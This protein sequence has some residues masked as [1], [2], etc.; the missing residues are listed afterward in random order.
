MASRINPAAQA[1]HNEFT[2]NKRL[3]FRSESLVFYAIFARMTETCL[4]LR[5]KVI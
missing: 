5:E 4:R 2:S 1:T 3:V